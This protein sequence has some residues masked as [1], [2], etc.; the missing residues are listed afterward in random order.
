MSSV[1]AKDS[2]IYSELIGS[3]GKVIERTWALKN[4]K[5]FVFFLKDGQSIGS[6]DVLQ[7]VSKCPN[8]K[9]LFLAKKGSDRVVNCGEKYFVLEL[10]DR[11]GVEIILRSKRQTVKNNIYLH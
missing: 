4:Q 1:K 5:I 3:I 8:S 7:A 10:S 6:E 11:E 9:F 2:P